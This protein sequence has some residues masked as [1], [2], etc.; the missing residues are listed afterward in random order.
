[1]QKRIEITKTSWKEQQLLLEADNAP[2]SLEGVTAS[3]QMLVDSDN[4]AFIYKL[5]TASEFIYVS[6]KDQF[7]K[8]MKTALVE[9]KVVVLVV[10]D[11]A[12]L[13][14]NIEEELG[15]LIDNIRDNANYGE[16][17]ERR[18]NEIF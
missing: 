10:G 17:M 1:M 14:T 2:F 8:D 9:K 16:E 6:I 13:L 5:E 4:L 15:Y 12:L 18:V 3:N 7:W 11:L